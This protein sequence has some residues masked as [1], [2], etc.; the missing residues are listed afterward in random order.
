MPKRKCQFSDRLSSKYKLFKDGRTKYEA[1]CLICP[2]GTYISVAN[3]GSQDLEIHLQSQKHKR[4]AQRCSAITDISSFFSQLSESALLINAAEAALAFHTVSHHSLYRSMDCTPKLNAEI[5]CDSDIAKNMSCVRTKTEAIINKILGPHSVDVTIQCL[6]EISCFGITTDG[7]N[8]LSLK[9]FPILIQFFDYKAGGIQSRVIELKTI[10]NETSDAISS[11]ISDTLRHLDIADKCVAFAGDNTNTNMGGFKRAESNSVFTK[12]KKCVNKNVVGIDCP[13]HIL[14]NTIQ[15]GAD[16]LGVDLECIV[17]KLYNYFSIYT[18][19]TEQLKEYCEFVDTDY[20]QL[21]SHTHTRWLSLFPAIYRILEMY[22]ALQSY[23]LS[24]PSPPK[25]LKDFFSARMS[26]AYLWHLHSLMSVFYDNIK[27][28]Q[29]ERNSII[30]II[31]ILENVSCLLENR[32]E[33]SFISLKTKEVLAS[34]REEGFGSEVDCFMEEAVSLYRECYGY[35]KK[36]SVSFIDFYCFRWMDL[37]EKVLM[38][39][40]ETCIKFLS[41]RGVKIDDKKCSDQL[42]HLNTFLEENS[43]DLENRSCNDKWVKYFGSSKHECHSELLKMAEYFFSLPGHNAN[44]ERVFSFIS[45][46]WTND[47]NTLN[48]DSVKG[49]LLVKY[50]YKHLSCSEFYKYIVSQQGILAEISSS[51][52]YG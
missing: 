46:Q 3:K 32:L 22:E 48:V 40:V 51:L 35:L 5:Y 47:R 11:Y 31:N 6:K 12:L 18:V 10:P 1:E 50:N 17:I 30:D 41:K 21:L 37:K 44:V 49:L 13:A 52:N 2:A 9:M 7:S 20:K 19:R 42:S 39:D 8:H 27:E 24:L 38:K 14:H 26:K 28:I 36:W 23:F 29:K 43:T 34:A 4:N 16:S 33:S 15:H 45:S 25:I